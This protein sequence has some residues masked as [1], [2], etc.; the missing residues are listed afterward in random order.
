MIGYLV[1]VKGLGVLIVLIPMAAAVA[2]A[3]ALQF[4]LSDV[5]FESGQA[6]LFADL[7]NQVIQHG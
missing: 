3:D 7:V 2:I 1:R 6:N 5:P 4:C